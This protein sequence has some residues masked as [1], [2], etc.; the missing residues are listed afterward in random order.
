MAGLWTCLSDMAGRSC[1][2]PSRG[3]EYASGEEWVRVHAPSI[4]ILKIRPQK[5]HYGRWKRATGEFKKQPFVPDII[6]G[7]VYVQQDTACE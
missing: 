2:E 5:E 3:L 1:T 6:E 7:F 4:L